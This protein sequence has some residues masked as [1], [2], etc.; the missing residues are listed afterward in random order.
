MKRLAVIATAA[1]LFGCSHRHPASKSTA[2]FDDAGRPK[3]TQEGSADVPAS[4]SVETLET[5]LEI[6]AGSVVSVTAPASAAIDPSHVTDKDARS[7]GGSQFPLP[8]VLWKDRDA[9][10]V[11]EPGPVTSWS[12]TF[13]DAATF[14]TITRREAVKAA[15]TPPPPSP[16]S[17]GETAAAEAVRWYYI[18]GAVFAV[19]AVLAFWRA[20]P[21]AGWFCVLGA[22]GVPALG[23]LV[24]SL[25][26]L[27]TL[28]GCAAVAFGLWWAWRALKSQLI[29]KGT[30]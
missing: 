16:P 6:P 26:A 25:A 20:Y 5:F 8:V 12:V 19:L 21:R 29:A 9:A 3:V 10:P 14:R 7:A 23:R 11:T 13:S 4:A 27:L 17:A 30:V 2:G 18:A 24:S 22:V 28:T 1:L 15:Q